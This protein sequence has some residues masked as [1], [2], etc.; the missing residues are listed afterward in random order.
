MLK[1][2]PHLKKYIDYLGLP[3]GVFPAIDEI[4]RAMDGRIWMIDN[5]SAMRELDSH[6]IRSAPD[7][8]WIE[9][10]DGVSRWSE[11]TQCIEFHAKMASRCWIPTQFR[12][13]NEPEGMPRKFT[14][15]WGHPDDVLSEREFLLN[16]L[17]HVG[18]ESRINPLAKQMRKL[19]RYLSRDSVILKAK[20]EYVSVIICTQGIPTDEHG[21]YDRYVLKEFV[22]SL[23]ELA[24]LPV[25]IV[26]RLTTDDD[27]VLEF[28]GS[29]DTKYDW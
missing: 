9:K 5:S 29:L 4:Y 19:S 27:K 23:A 24:A 1:N 17:Q 7:F 22:D 18:L 11:L 26:F 20:D 12:L 25:K 28:F 2:S 3:N 14:V 16:N 10:R 6:L 15:C 21:N 13:L 8:E